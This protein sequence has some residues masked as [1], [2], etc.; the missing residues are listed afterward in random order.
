MEQLTLKELRELLEVRFPGVELELEYVKPS[1]KI[2]GSVVW[3][4]FVG[5]D[6]VKRQRMV[7]K[8]LEERVSR[9]KQLQVS[10]LL[11]F[12]PEESTAIHKG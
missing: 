2:F 8:V 12:T 4:G 6:Q 5:K 11:T 7:W 1:K 3:R 10:A 9:G